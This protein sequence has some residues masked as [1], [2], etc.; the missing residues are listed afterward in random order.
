[1]LGVVN[2]LARQEGYHTRGKCIPYFF[3]QIYQNILNLDFYQSHQVPTEEGE[4]FNAQKE[5][6]SV[7]QRQALLLNVSNVKLADKK[8]EII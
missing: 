8:S 3:F 1:M 5:K 6:H 2:A 4:S 7:D